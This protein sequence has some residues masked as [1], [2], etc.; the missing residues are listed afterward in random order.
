MPYDHQLDHKVAEVFN[1][2]VQYF[3]MLHRWHDEQGGIAIEP[4]VQSLISTH[5]RH[6]SMV[7]EAGSGAGN[8]TNWFAARYPDT[9][10]VG[11]DISAIG[12]ALARERAPVNAAFAV[13]DLKRLSFAD[14]AFDFVFSQSVLEH[15]VG[16]DV[17][18]GELHRIL[19]PRGHLLIRLTNAGVHCKSLRR[20][21]LAYLLGRNRASQ[22]E[23]S[24]ELSSASDWRGHMTNY[25]VHQ[26]PSDVLLTTLRRTGFS[27]SYFTTGTQHWRR[28][29]DVG[30]RLVSYLGFWP[31]SHLGATSIVLATKEPRAS[32]TTQYSGRLP[33]PVSRASR[34]DRSS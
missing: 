22:V 5:C 16:W 21:L 12:V 28:N 19:Q 33:Y 13:A 15:V 17:A 18:L 32:R 7:L 14:R 3:E 26:I 27:I 6:G 24:F 34:C 10:F 11:V 8:I 20:A 1:S 23:P 29:R 4:E 9:R 2:N 31:F 30:S 25:D